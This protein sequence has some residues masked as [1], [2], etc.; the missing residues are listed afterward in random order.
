MAHDNMIQDANI[1]QAQRF[2]EPL[3]NPPIG[4]AGLVVNAGTWRVSGSCQAMHHV[5]RS[6]RLAATSRRMGSHQPKKRNQADTTRAA[7]GAALFCA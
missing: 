6:H 4:V 7:T 2:F 5:R 3:G 1:H